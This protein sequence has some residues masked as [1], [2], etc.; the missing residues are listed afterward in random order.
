M[1]IFS[2][3]NISLLETLKMSVLIEAVDIRFYSAT[4]IPSM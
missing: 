2:I 4:R 3:N 1:M